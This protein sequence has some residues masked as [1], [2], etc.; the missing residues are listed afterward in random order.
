M[1]K[2][3]VFLWLTALMLSL[4][5]SLAIA[6]HSGGGGF[7]GNGGAQFH[8]NGQFHGDRGHHDGRFFRD[9]RGHRVFIDGGPFFFAPFFYD[10]V[11]PYDNQLIYIQPSADADYS[12]YCRSPAGYY[13]DVQ[14]CPSGWLRVRP[15]DSSY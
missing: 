8:E 14:R 9:F 13:P 1:K 11:Y 10:G 2:K 15:D 3:A 5:S 12:Y 7:H 4:G 6:Q